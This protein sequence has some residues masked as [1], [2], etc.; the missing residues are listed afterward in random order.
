MRL[1]WSFVIVMCLLMCGCH[2]EVPTPGSI[3]MVGSKGDIIEINPSYT[4][5]LQ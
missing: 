5:T 4:P 2:R 3:E 1:R